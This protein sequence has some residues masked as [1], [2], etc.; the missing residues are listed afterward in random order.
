VRAGAVARRRATA[1]DEQLPDALRVLAAELGAGRT[2]E[3]ALDS[4]AGRTSAPLG[5]ALAQA[6]RA[7]LRG[8][9][10][11]DALSDALPSSDGVQ[12][13]AAAVGLQRRL[14][15]DLPRLC[16]DLGHTLE[17]R[18]RVEADVRSMTAQARWS[19]MVVPLL[20]PLGLLGMLAVDPVGVRLLLTTA[21]GLVLVAAAL[22]LD[23]TGAVIIRRLAAAIG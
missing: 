3:H 13:L 22:L 6:A 10:L 17:E 2:F 14:G 20:P 21:P 11:D 1:I 7:H 18:A 16:R 15:G 9:P 8:R 5:A 23:A 12:L 4:T 19:A